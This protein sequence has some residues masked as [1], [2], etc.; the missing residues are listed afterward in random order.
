MVGPI[1]ME[2]DRTALLV[3]IG[4]EAGVLEVGYKGLLALN[5]RVRDF[6]LLLRVELLPLLVV[7][8]LIEWDQR[9]ADV[10]LV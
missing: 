3:L 5:A 1:G 9:P 10:S 7:E 2:D 8:F 4:H 6:T